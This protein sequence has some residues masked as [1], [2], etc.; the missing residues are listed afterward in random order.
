MKGMKIMKETAENMALAKTAE[1]AKE[2][3]PT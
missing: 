3:E 1:G 2:G